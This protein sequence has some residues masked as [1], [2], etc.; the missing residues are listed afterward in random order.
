MKRFCNLLPNVSVSHCHKFSYFTRY[1]NLFSSV[2]QLLFLTLIDTTITLA[3]DTT[4]TPFNDI[5]QRVP[6]CG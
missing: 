4:T 3:I 6:S 5:Q 1:Q 2:S